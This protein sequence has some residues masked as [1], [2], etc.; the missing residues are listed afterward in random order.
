LEVDDLMADIAAVFHW[1]PSEMFSM[2]L[3]EVIRWRQQ[4][5]KRSEAGSE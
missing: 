1:Q 3:T 5:I 4:A 2:T